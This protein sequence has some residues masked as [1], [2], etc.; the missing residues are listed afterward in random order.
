M[1][2]ERFTRNLP[3]ILGVV[4]R[5]AARYRADFEPLLT[6]HVG[7]GDQSIAAA[8]LLHA[9]LGRGTILVVAGRPEHAVY[10]TPLG[11]R[12]YDF[13]LYADALGH[14][15]PAR[16]AVEDT[17]YDTLPLDLRQ[18]PAAVFDACEAAARDSGGDGYAAIIPALRRVRQDGASP[19]E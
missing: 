17:L 14:D 9:T 12:L 7:S 5:Q 16:A 15:A 11:S 6:P 18:V 8:L 4:T 1:D 19:E 10:R 13:D 2:P 3:K